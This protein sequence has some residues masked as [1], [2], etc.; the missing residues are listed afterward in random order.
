M[1]LDSDINYNEC[2][3]GFEPEAGMVDPEGT[4]ETIVAWQR[5]TGEKKLRSGMSKERY[6]RW[7]AILYLGSK[8]A[9]C[10][11]DEDIRALQIDHIYGGGRKEKRERVRGLMYR[12]VAEGKRADIQLLCANCNHIKA[13]KNKEFFHQI[14]AKVH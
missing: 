2:P 4:L 13:H 7:Q 1:D 5:G 10:G 14:N 11:Y 9:G 12:E 3:P 6:W 8:C